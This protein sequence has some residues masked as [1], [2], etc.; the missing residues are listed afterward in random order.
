MAT[1]FDLW[2]EHARIHW[3]KDLDPYPKS[4]S[5][6]TNSPAH[7]LSASLCNCKWIQ[8]LSIHLIS[9]SIQIWEV[10]D[11]MWCSLR[12]SPW[13]IHLLNNVD[14]VHVWHEILLKG[15]VSTCSSSHFILFWTNSLKGIWLGSH[16][17]YLSRFNVSVEV[18]LLMQSPTGILLLLLI[19]PWIIYFDTSRQSSWLSGN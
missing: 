1:R 14:K 15:K 17:Q 3:R 12:S 10:K 4:N 13:S 5:T 19:S 18:E 16:K 8:C 11:L 2:I 9:Q 7:R 6:S